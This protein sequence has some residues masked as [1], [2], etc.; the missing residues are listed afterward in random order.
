MLKMDL[1]Y[2]SGVFFIRLIGNL[3]KSNTHKLNNYILPILKKHKIKKVIINLSKI[4]TIDELGVE[5]ILNIKCI[6][7]LNKGDVRLCET[8]YF[9][10]SKLK[11]L[12]I[13]NF[14]SEYAALKQ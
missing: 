8:D 12:H 5:A 1:E 4:N 2:E 14:L 13:K 6:V 10:L 11:R 9:T 7:K 3:T